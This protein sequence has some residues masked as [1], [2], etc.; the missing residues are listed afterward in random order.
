[1]INIFRTWNVFCKDFNLNKR[2]FQQQRW[3]DSLGSRTHPHY[4]G[5]GG[6]T[7]S[8]NNYKLMEKL[9]YCQEAEGLRSL[10]RLLRMR[11]VMLMAAL[12]YF[13]WG[14]WKERTASRFTSFCLTHNSNDQINSH[15]WY[16][17]KEKK[18]NGRSLQ[19]V[20]IFGDFVLKKFHDAFGF[21]WIIIFQ[22]KCQIILTFSV[23]DGA[24]SPK[25]ELFE[26]FFFLLTFTK[27][28]NNCGYGLYIIKIMYL[29]EWAKI[30]TVC[31]IMLC[32]PTMLKKLTLQTNIYLPIT[33]KYVF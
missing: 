27:G 18:L 14:W 30:E 4:D 10:T 26:L 16:G 24:T 22:F 2:S 20:C 29:K 25:G 9:T 33:N 21:L 32:S 19:I 23:W 3:V 5:P 31:C 15:L 7:R 11:G 12:S 6:E 8:W 13:L 28:A 1:M 17:V